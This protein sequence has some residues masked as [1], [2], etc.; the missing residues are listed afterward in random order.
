MSATTI[1]QR[2]FVELPRLRAA[3]RLSKIAF[4]ETALSIDGAALVTGR[5]KTHRSVLGKIYRE[6]NARTWESLGDL[7][8]LK[9]IFPTNRGVVEFTN[10]LNSQAD[11]NPRLEVI[12]SRAN[13]LRYE[14]MQFD[15]WCSTL[16]DY[17][18]APIKIELQVRT[19]AADAWYVVDHRLRYKGSVKLPPELERKLYRLIVLTELFDQEVETV[20][21]QQA[22]LPE[23]GVAR[24]YETLTREMDQLIDGHAKTSRP[25]GLL[26]LVLSSYSD[27]EVPNLEN[28]MT[29]FLEEKRGA[30]RAVIVDHLHDAAN[31]VEVRDWLYYEPEALLIAE[32]ATSRPSLLAARITGSDFEGVIGAMVGEFGARLP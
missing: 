21:A 7:V 13:E 19:S 15:L 18:G 11:W 16:T 6:G 12:R 30:I 14:S 3:L 31:F 26:E 22:S 20:I 2:Y 24:L 25:E 1:S 28:L 29:E 32:R 27:D 23:Y 9:A 8:A 17:T 10:W 4:E 5:V